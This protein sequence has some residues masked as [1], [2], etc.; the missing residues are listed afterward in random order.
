[1]YN[2]IQMNT[3]NV[4]TFYPLTTNSH[5]YHLSQLNYINTLINIITPLRKRI[6]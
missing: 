1:M 6:N 3:L 5:S 4:L 2:L